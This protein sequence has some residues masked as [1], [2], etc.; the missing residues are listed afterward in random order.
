MKILILEDIYSTIDQLKT[1]FDEKKWLYDVASKVATAR[2]LCNKNKYDCYIIDLIV[3]PVG[4]TIEEFNSY[5][6]YYGWAWFHNYILKRNIEK[7]S[8]LRKQAIIFSAYSKTF[9]EKFRFEADGV[10]IIDKKEENAEE[11]LLKKIE[12][13][14]KMNDRDGN[15]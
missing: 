3:I 4:L 12:E 9:K 1:M 6:P 10:F 15:K 13:I 11:K 7:S 8:I 2:D 14:L 5:G